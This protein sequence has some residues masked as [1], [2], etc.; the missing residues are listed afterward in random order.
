MSEAVH[1]ANAFLVASGNSKERRMENVR[2]VYEKLILFSPF[3][4]EERLGALSLA[5]VYIARP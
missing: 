4:R 1:C 5:L 2:G 3:A